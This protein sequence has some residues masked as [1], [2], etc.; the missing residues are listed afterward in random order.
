MTTKRRPCTETW[1]IGA[2]GAIVLAVLSVWAARAIRGDLRD[3]AT[4]RARNLVRG[5]DGVAAMGTAHEAARAWRR[6]RGKLGEDY[7]LLPMEKRL[8][9]PST[10][11]GKYFAEDKYGRALEELI[12]VRELEGRKRP[13]LFEIYVAGLAG[14][15]NWL[16]ECLAR[17]NGEEDELRAL[18][19]RANLSWAKG[20]DANLLK[21]T[22]PERWLEMARQ[23]DRKQNWE[24]WLR[25]LRAR[26]F[27]RLGEK[28]QAWQE[29]AAE[30]E[31]DTTSLASGID[32]LVHYLVFGAQVAEETGHAAAAL[33]LAMSAERF[34]DGIIQRSWSRDRQLLQAMIKRLSKARAASRGSEVGQIPRD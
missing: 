28:A 27:V 23:A 9:G 2:G 12:R 32:F 20:D 21:A 1:V 18:F 4:K 26:A 29:L 8:R 25:F 22:R 30:I 7:Y 24:L 6:I 15:E 10:L 3:S 19:I 11:A 33:E 13:G 16:R 14:R 5:W 34:L 17:S 31:G